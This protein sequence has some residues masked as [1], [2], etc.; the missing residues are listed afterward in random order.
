MRVKDRRRALCDTCVASMPAD[1]SGTAGG[2]RAVAPVYPESGAFSGAPRQSIGAARCANSHCGT[3]AQL[4]KIALAGGSKAQ[5]AA[6]MAR[7]G[8]NGSIISPCGAWCCEEAGSPGRA[9]S[10][11][12]RRSSRGL[13]SYRRGTKKYGCHSVS[14][15]FACRSTQPIT[16]AAKV[17]GV[18]KKQVAS[19]HPFNR[20]SLLTRTL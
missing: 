4:R 14:S 10:R 8:E 2:Q 1:R 16:V 18:D 17:A 12:G 19:R 6:R 15:V 9:G 20:K 11:V 7:T 13:P 3:R 5:R